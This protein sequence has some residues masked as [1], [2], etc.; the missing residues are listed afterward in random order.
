MN[1][2][3]DTLQIVFRSVLLAASAFYTFFLLLHRG[4]WHFLDNVD[5]IIHEAGHTIFFFLGDFMQI[6]AGSLFQVAIPFVFALYFL[7]RNEIFSSGIVFLWMSQSLANVSVYIADAERMSLPLLGGEGS[8]HDWNYLLSHTGL[9]SLTPQVTMCIVM[10]SVIAM[11]AG[12][13]L[14]GVDIYRFSR[15]EDTQR[16]SEQSNAT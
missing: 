3:V 12:I 16:G 1:G 13:A 15:S 5:L 10:L 7:L 2:R 9:L 8:I 14:M 11:A 6:L 4:E